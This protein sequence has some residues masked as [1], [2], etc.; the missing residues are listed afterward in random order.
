MMPSTYVY[1]YPFHVF[2]FDFTTSAGPTL[3][4]EDISLLLTLCKKHPKK[5]GFILMEFIMMMI[6]M[7]M[8]V[9]IM[10]ITKNSLTLKLQ[11]QNY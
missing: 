10:N 9:N 3:W 8:V 11:C 6:L 7:I 4:L 1:V 5:I 2:R